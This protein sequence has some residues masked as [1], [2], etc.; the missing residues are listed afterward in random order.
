MESDN[1]FG[2]LV[3]LKTGNGITKSVL[4]GKLITTDQV[5]FDLLFGKVKLL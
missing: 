4:I 2:D 1:S 5:W 3:T